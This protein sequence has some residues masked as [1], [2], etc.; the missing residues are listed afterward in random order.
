MKEWNP[1]LYMQFKSERTQPSIDLIARINQVAPR[2]IIDLG[3]GPGNSTQV[4]VNRW[5]DAHVTGLDSSKAMIHKARQDYPH[6]EWLVADILSHDPD[7]K[8]DIVFSNAVIQWIP[9][10][11]ELLK[12]FQRMLLNG[13][14]VAI[15]VPLFWEMPLGKCIKNIADEGRWKPHMVGVSDLLTIHDYPFYYDCL[16]DLFTSIEIWE[17]QYLHIMDSHESILEMMRSTGLKPYLEKLET[18]SE[19]EKFE[20]DVLDQISRAYPRQKDGKVL[21]PFKRLFFIGRKR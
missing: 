14:V 2:S 1:N 12:K 15:Q 17:T 18:D 7:V 3:C 5:P 20:G 8:Y 6:Q 16:S 11:V 21:L 19:K 13:G 10:H 4:L 9:D